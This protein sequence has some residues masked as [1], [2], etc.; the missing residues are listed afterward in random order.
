MN[1]SNVKALFRRAQAEVGQNRLVEA[2]G[3]M[4]TFGKPVTSADSLPSR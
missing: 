2:Q 1:P 4:C 3:G